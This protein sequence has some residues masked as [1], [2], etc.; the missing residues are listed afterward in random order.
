[1]GG[2]VTTAALVVDAIVAEF[3]DAT[4]TGAAG[5]DEEI[6]VGRGFSVVAFVAVIV[7]ATDGNV[8]ITVFIDVVEV[9]VDDNPVS[10]VD[11]VD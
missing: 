4:T 10:D 3:D 2:V 11:I 7:A 8:A 9:P 6:F 5:E 1:M